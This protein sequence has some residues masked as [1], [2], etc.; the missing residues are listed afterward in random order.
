MEQHIE[1]WYLENQN[2]VDNAYMEKLMEEY[3]FDVTESSIDLMPT[4]EFIED[5]YYAWKDN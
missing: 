1:E 3:G 5:C 4:D 2:D